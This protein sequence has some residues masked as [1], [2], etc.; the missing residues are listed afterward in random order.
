MA[1]TRARA[2]AAANEKATHGQGR[3]LQGTS[4]V[5]PLKSKL[6]V[7]VRKGGGG[8]EEKEEKEPPRGVPTR[9]RRVPPEFPVPKARRTKVF[10]FEQRYGNHRFGLPYN[11]F[12]TVQPPPKPAVKVSTILSNVVPVKPLTLHPSSLPVK[13]PSK[14]KP[15]PKPKPEPKPLPNPSPKLSKKKARS[16]TRFTK[17]KPTIHSS[18]AVRE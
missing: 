11:L 6:V 1:N 12:P 15:K 5:S 16:A 2:R 10:P 9:K 13:S 3:K 18:P 4:E 17:E 7:N 8:E 14:P